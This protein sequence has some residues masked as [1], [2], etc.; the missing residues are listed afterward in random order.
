MLKREIMDASSGVGFAKGAVGAAE[1]G[2]VDNW[3]GLAEAFGMQRDLGRAHA[4]IYIALEPLD[5]VGIA[6]RLGIPVDLARA[7]V[8][9]LIDWKVVRKNEAEGAATTYATELDPWVW[10]LKIVSERHHREFSKVLNAMRRTLADVHTLDASNPAVREL[11][12][13]ADRFTKFVEDLSNLIEL[14]LRLGQKPMAAVLRTVAK[15]A[16]RA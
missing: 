10:F 4:L 16:P 12:N 5:D 6:G 11:R 3:G 8:E 9:E 7:H 1:Q 13:R 14:F 2:F 15:F